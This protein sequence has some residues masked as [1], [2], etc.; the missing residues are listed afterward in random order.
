M[1]CPLHHDILGTGTGSHTGHFRADA[2][3]YDRLTERAPCDSSCM[4][5][6]NFMA[7]GMCDRRFA[8][9][10]ELAAHK[11]LGPVS[12][13]MTVKEFSRNNAA[14][15]FNL[16]YISVNC[17]LKHFINHFKISGEIGAFQAAGQ[18]YI[19]IKI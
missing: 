4:Y 8:F 9:H 16:V 18:V 12:I 2:L 14:E 19:N 3:T 15:L 5:L 13:L 17:L 10:H 6:D 1:I 11:D 7:D